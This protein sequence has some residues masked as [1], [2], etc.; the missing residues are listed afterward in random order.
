MGRYKIHR[1]KPE[2]PPHMIDGLKDFDSILD[3]SRQAKSDKKIRRNSRISIVSAAVALFMIIIF[4][5][6]TLRNK[7]FKNGTPKEAPQGVIHQPDE[8]S[9]MIDSEKNESM[10]RKRSL[11]D[12][13]NNKISDELNDQFDKRGDA[14]S[15]FKEDKGQEDH[16]LAEP[17]FHEAKPV[18]GFDHLYQYFNKNLKSNLNLEEDKTVIVFFTVTNEGT[19]KNVYVQD[20]A[21]EYIDSVAVSLVEKMPNWQPAK[22]GQKP[23]NTELSIPLNFKNQ[24]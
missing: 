13:G 7:F 23:I 12:M 8:K 11:N 1:K 6:P 2:L 24:K 14:N 20:S 19:I 17:V 18:N 4:F 22:I 9:T 16:Q 3:R 15:E 10:K 5:I 21:G